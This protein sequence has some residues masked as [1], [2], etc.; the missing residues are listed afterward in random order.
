MFAKILITDSLLSPSNCD[1]LQTIRAGAQWKDSTFTIRRLSHESSFVRARSAKRV[2]A[3]HLLTHTLAPSHPQR[4]RGNQLLGEGQE[5]GSVNG[6]LG[7]AIVR[8]QIDRLS[9]MFDGRKCIQPNG[10]FAPLFVFL[11]TF[12]GRAH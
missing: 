3:H 4:Q 5:P 8:V 6:S 7:I 1:V 9:N 12:I 10:S 11:S 2:V